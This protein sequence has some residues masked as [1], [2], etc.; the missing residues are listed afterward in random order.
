MND[1]YTYAYLREDGTPYYIGKGRGKR[2]FQKHRKNLP[3]PPENRLLLL[4][5][6][7]TEK[8]AF[9]HEI[10][11]IAVFGRKNIGTG[12]LWNFTDGGQGASG[13]GWTEEERD[14]LRKPWGDARRNAEENKKPSSKRS[15]AQK[16]RRE[17]E[18]ENGII[19]VFGGKGK[20]HWTLKE[21][22]LLSQAEII[23]QVWK[24]NGKPKDHRTLCKLLK[25]PKTKKV[26]SIV[27]LLSEENAD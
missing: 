26:M 19:I 27:K 11:M 17:K 3:V 23:F 1:F 7:L 18:K 9:K 5:T 13:R 2:A 16:A 15:P 24:E 4:K 6:R 25:I 14:K 8:E 22:P 21:D 10:Y 12:I 20:S